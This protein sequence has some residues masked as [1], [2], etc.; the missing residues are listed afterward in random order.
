VD[1]LELA[2][3]PDTDSKTLITLASDEN[4]GIRSYVA[5]NPSAPQ[6]ALITLASDQSEYV[7]SY[8][9]RNPSAPREALESLLLDPKIHDTV[10]NI[11]LERSKKSG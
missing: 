9:A 8:V 11:L 1:K 2:I 7:R 4:K 10:I 5:R 6:E 3:D